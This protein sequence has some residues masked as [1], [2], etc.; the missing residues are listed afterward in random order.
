MKADQ[1][2]Q[3]SY[4]DNRRMDLEFQVGEHVYLKISPT[5]G[6]ICFGSSRKLKPR[7]IRPFELL[8]RVGALAYKLALSSNLLWVHDVFHVSMVNKY[9]ED[10]SDIIPSFSDL[11]IQPNAIYVEKSVWILARED[12]VLR[13]KG[14]IIGKGVL[15][16][17]RNW[18]SNV[19]IW[20]GYE[21]RIP[22]VILNI[23]L[24]MLLYNSM[25]W[26][27]VC[28]FGC[29]WLLASYVR[30]LRLMDIVSILTFFDF[31]WLKSIGQL[32]PIMT[33]SD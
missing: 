13:K 31:R 3:K 11:K 27:V 5:K 2:W 20:E 25:K 9:I 6:V 23:F 14:Y 33:T 32:I 8:K 30:G 29:Y 19:R 24:L 4:V 17:P 12:K 28:S 7:Y 16:K 15:E 26:I 22:R 1:D 21:H 10:D 18:G